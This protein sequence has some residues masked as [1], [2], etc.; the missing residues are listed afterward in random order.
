MGKNKEKL[1][2][3]SSTLMEFF[4]AD[5][6]RK[7][8]VTTDATNRLSDEQKAK[9]KGIVEDLKTQVDEF[10]AGNSS[11]VTPNQVKDALQPKKKTLREI[12][13]EKKQNDT[14]NETPTE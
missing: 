4:V 13:R 8:N 14:D 7:N 5:V 6:F 10:L 9:I 1:T 3:L 11:D 12:I 2:E